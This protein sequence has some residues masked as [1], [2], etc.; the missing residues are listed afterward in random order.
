M[1]SILLSKYAVSSFTQAFLG[2]L[3]TAYLL[4]SA[5]KN[6]SAW[7]LIA[8]F[9]AITIS[10]MSSFLLMA[11]QAPWRVWFGPLQGLVGFFGFIAITQFA[12]TFPGGEASTRSRR[13]LILSLVGLLG[14]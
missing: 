3:I 6:C 13:A 9:A 14:V 8:F 2:L 11:V 5:N 4:V 7:R 10:M 1:E 12:Y